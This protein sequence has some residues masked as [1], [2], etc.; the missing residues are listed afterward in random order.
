[1]IGEI[2]QAGGRRMKKVKM[3]W[4]SGKILMLAILISRSVSVNERF[5]NNTKKFLYFIP[6]FQLPDEYTYLNSMKYAKLP[7]LQALWSSFLIYCI[8]CSGLTVY[9]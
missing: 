9:I 8:V 3:G 7:V 1:M 6:A 4:K 5:H 2:L